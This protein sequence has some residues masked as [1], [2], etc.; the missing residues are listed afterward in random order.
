MHPPITLY[1]CS[2]QFATPTPPLCLPVLLYLFFLPENM[3]LLLYNCSPNVLPGELPGGGM[4]SY[5]LL[6]LTLGIVL[7]VWQVL[8]KYAN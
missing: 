6:V 4:W 8:S 1:L 3:A 5:S 2:S 7:G